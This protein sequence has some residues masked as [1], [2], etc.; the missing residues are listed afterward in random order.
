MSGSSIGVDQRLPITN[1]MDI[2]WRRYCALRITFPSGASYRGTGFFIG[3][4][5]VATAGH[6]VYLRNQGGW[7][8]KIEVIPGNN[9]SKRPF[10]QAE[11]LRFYNE[12]PQEDGAAGMG[13]VR[14]AGGMTIAQNEESCVVFGM[15]KAAIDRGYVTRVVHLE[16]LPNTLQAQCAPERSGRDSGRTQATSAGSN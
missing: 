2:P 11:Y 7:A 6:C 4:R 14:A 3:P 9:G 5:A 10:G 1:T 13:A 15:P 8:R 16:D 12:P